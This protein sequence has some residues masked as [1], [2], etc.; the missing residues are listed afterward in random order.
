MRPNNM[1]KARQTGYSSRAR[2]QAGF[3]LIELM[4][5]IAIG[6]LILA[7]MLTVFVNTSAARNEI[8]LMN[9]QIENGRYATELLRDDIQLSSFYGEIDMIKIRLAP[10]LPVTVP[11]P[12]ATS[13]AERSDGGNV[14]ILLV[15]VQGIDNFDPATSTELDSCPTIKSA[16]KPGTDIIVIRRAKTCFAGVGDC[17]S[18]NYLA[19]LVDGIRKPV[20]QISLCGLLAPISPSGITTHALA[21]YP[22]PEFVHRLKGA[23]C[24]A[25]T[26]AP[27]RPYVI[28]MYFVGTDNILKRV[29]FVDGTGMHINNVMPLVDG[30][31]NLQVEYGVDATDD[32][33][34]DGAYKSAAEIKALA[35]AAAVADW[36]NVVTV[37]VNLLARNTERSPS[38]TDSKTYDLG[39]FPGTIKTSANN[40]VP[41]TVIAGRT[42]YGPWS[43]LPATDPDIAYRRHVYSSLVRITNVSARRER[44]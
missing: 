10:G 5:A 24:A 4:I 2:H 31:E 25:A 32:G 26:A 22:N 9:R 42:L 29:K 21:V 36:S 17:D 39:Q 28:Y 19:G 14:G 41:T 44:P 37:K 13:L 43:S 38:Y 3:S 1:K 34:A 40:N 11:D 20:L 12:C 18:L 35:P 27:L 7:G 23:N 30:I 6:L 33:N 16:V 8:D 15:H